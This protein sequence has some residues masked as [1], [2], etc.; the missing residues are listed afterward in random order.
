M[1]E[2]Q[3]HYQDVQSLQ[4]QRITLA[5]EAEV[6]GILSHL[7]GHAMAPE[8]REFVGTVLVLRREQNAARWSKSAVT[9]ARLLAVE[10]GIDVV[11]SQLVRQAKEL[12]ALLA[13]Q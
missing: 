5:Q 3:R 2:A 13:D 4:A 8:F 9:A 12:N 1:R 7:T 11:L 6:D 10:S